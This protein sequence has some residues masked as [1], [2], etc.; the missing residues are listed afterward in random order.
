MSSSGSHEAP[1]WRGMDSN[2]RSPQ[3]KTPG[4]GIVLLAAALELR[5][6]PHRA[7]VKLPRSSSDQIYRLIS[8]RRIGRI[9]A[10][11]GGHRDR[12]ASAGR[13]GSRRQRRGP[14]PDWLSSGDV[15]IK[16]MLLSHIQE[17]EKTVL[18]ET[19]RAQVP[20]MLEHLHSAGSHTRRL[21][22][23]VRVGKH[24]LELLMDKTATGVKVEDP[25]RFV[26]TRARSSSGTYAGLIWVALIIA[27]IIFLIVSQSHR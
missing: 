17:M 10:R 19:V 18:V 24:E 15:S 7:S 14:L 1:R 2:P 5:L 16:Q 13:H 11:L 23:I 8:A 27:F 12:L 21:A 20:V 25:A 9:G 4:F 6:L 3:L 26:S 22:Q